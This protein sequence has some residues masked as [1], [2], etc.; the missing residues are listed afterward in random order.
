MRNEWGDESLRDWEFP[1][2]KRESCMTSWK[3]VWTVGKWGQITDWEAAWLFIKKWNE[4]KV[5]KWNECKVLLLKKGGHKTKTEM[6]TT[7]LSPSRHDGKD[8]LK[9]PIWTCETNDIS[10]RSYGRRAEWIQNRPERIGEH[11][12][13][14]W[15]DW[16]NEKG[17]EGRLHGFSGQ[18]ERIWQSE[19]EHPVWGID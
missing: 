13:G 1:S 11:V 17:W 18:W 3:T 15:D 19:S 12:C 10:A 9:Y 6:K 8:Y 2:E 7:A 4:E 5:P 14:H 16:K